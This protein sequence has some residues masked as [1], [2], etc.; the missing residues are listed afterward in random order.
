[1]V[2]AA[3]GE[4]RQIELRADANSAA[5]QK[6]IAEIGRDG[7]ISIELLKLVRDGQI[8]ITPEVY[9]SGDNAGPM[10][11]LAATMLGGRHSAAAPVKEI[12]QSA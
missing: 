10:T 3:E 2:A 1:M 4:A 6:L 8:K 9:V 11:A 12:P 5:Y 7:L